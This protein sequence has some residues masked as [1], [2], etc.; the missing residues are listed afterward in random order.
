MSELA[1]D[2]KKTKID[3]FL[4]VLHFVDQDTLLFELINKTSTPLLV[5][6]SK[7]KKG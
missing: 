1:D 3:M 5:Q 6:R 4:F 2:E 7:Q